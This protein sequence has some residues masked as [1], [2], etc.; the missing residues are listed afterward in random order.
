M[1][2]GKPTQD[3][4]RTQRENEREKK[5]EMRKMLLLAAMAAIAALMLAAT[6]AFADDNNDRDNHDDFCDIFD[7]HNFND[8]NDFCDFHDCNRNDFCDFHDCNR[9]DF[10]DF[11]NCNN[12]VV[13]EISQENEQNAESGDATQNINVSGGGDN[14]N[15]IA[16]VQGVVNTGNA[17]NQIGITQIGSDTDDFSFEDSAASINVSPTNTTSGTQQVNQAA[18][19]SGSNWWWMK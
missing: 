8:H 9:N 3:E 4:S 2:L 5:I 15:Q 16:G 18:S 19:A 12:F 10:C 1:R 17:Q 11:H 6:P 7:C 13:P 14:S